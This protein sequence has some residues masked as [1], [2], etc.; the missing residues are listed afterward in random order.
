MSVP[1]T[2]AQATQLLAPGVQTDVAHDIVLLAGE[3]NRTGV[4]E[5]VLVRRGA[6]W[7]NI[8]PNGYPEVCPR[9]LTGD[10]CLDGR[11]HEKG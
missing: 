1:G 7:G 4:R 5:M 3:V 8:I 10:R 11:R 2:R 9:V 6:P